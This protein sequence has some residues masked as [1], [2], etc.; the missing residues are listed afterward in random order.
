MATHILQIA[1]YP[2]L[3][4]TRSKMLKTAGYQVTSVLGNES[5][6]ALPSAVLAAVNL[7]VVGFSSDHSIRS[8]MVHWLKARHPDIPV[9]A[10]QAHDWEEFSEADAA[11]KIEDP[12]AWLAA[13]VKTR[14]P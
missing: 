11:M 7:V 8:A 5:A 3:Q 4:E 12:K 6:M 14:K 10:L 2:M 13:V 9:I 1:Y